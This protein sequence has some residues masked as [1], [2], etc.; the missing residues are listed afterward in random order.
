MTG[1]GLVHG[2]DAARWGGWSW[3]DPCRGEHFRR[4]SFCGSI[5][6]EDLAAEP[7][8]DCAICGK[9]GGL[10][11]DYPDYPAPGSVSEDKRAGHPYQGGWHAEWADRKYGWPHK[12]YV[13]IPNR[14]PGE[15]F[16]IGSQSGGPPGT[17]APASGPTMTWV[18]V[19]DLSRSQRKIIK[20]DGWD[21]G[22]KLEGYYGFGT[23]SSHFGKFYTVHLADPAV[24]DE[25]RD[26]IQSRSGL[27]F[28][29]EGGRVAW[30]HYAAPG[31]PPSAP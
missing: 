5:H 13:D 3:S 8:G 14:N 30:E 28:R 23:R 25:V 4:C 24:S 16:V 31:A 29:F 11:H 1:S 9:R 21:S 12:F 22:R 18:A 2:A 6:P 26:A 17:P 15:L 10:S 20:R 27:R 19:A 7:A